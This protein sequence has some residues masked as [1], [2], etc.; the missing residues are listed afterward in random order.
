MFTF[1]SVF[2]RW[3]AIGHLRIE[4]FKCEQSPADENAFLDHRF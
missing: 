1:N 2:D 4:H 3:N